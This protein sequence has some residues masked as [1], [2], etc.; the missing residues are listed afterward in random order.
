MT[1]PQPW[2]GEKGPQPAPLPESKPPPP[3]AP[4]RKHAAFPPT[5]EIPDDVRGKMPECQ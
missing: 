1:M 4:P 5:L 2:S 3:P